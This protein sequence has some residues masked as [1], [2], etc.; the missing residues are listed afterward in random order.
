MRALERLIAILE[1][2]ADDSVAATTTAISTRVGLSLSTTSRLVKELEQEGLIERTY[3][4][5]PFTLGRPVPG[6][7]EV[8]D[9]A[10][11]PASTP[12]CR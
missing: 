8:G 2:V 9:P 5:G 10:R 11:Q 3:E 1:A 4:N 6:A 7:G 12:R